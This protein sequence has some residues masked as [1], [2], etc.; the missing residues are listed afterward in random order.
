V[1]NEVVAHYVDGR[2]L[3]GSS[4]DIDP[5]RPI[6]HLRVGDKQTIEV[7]LA[8]LKALFFVRSLTGDPAHTEGNTVEAGDPRS[9]GAHPIE[10]EFLDGE[11]VVGLTVRYPPVR[12]F[13]YVVPADGRSNN[14]RILVNRAAVV[15]LGQP[16]NG[17]Y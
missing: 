6:F 3:K 5:A 12:P 9:R 4:H 15:R 8:D 10:V 11:R 2:V 13:F 14:L 17:V 7:K 16:R 1:A